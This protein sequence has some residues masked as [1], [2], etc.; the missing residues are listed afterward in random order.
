MKDNIK[1]GLL[2]LGTIGSGVAKILTERVEVIHSRVKCPL[3]LAQAADLDE[4]KKSC[5]PD[6]SVFT[7][8][9]RSVIESPDIDIIIELIG[10]ETPA[11]DFIREAITII[12]ATVVRDLKGVGMNGGVPVVAVVAPAV[13]VNVP[14]PAVI[15]IATNNAVRILWCI[16]VTASTPRTN[17]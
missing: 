1:I 6:P 3:S 14:V 2:G 15:V 13:L 11:K 5:L 7:T 10:G 4:S 17:K 9:A 16:V 12:I 8:D